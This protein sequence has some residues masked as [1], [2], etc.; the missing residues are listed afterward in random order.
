MRPTNPY[1]PPD[2][3]AVA[4]FSPRFD[5]GKLAAKYLQLL[6]CLSVAAT[7]VGL[8]FF[9]RLNLDISPLLLFW[10]SKHLAN[11]GK[12]A[13]K[14]VIGICYFN[15]IGIAFLFVLTLYYG[16][17]KDSPIEFR[18]GIDAPGILQIALLSCILS[19]LLVIPVWIL[20]TPE[21]KREFAVE[22]G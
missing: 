22:A 18:S 15:L 14:W 11:H 9:D 19:V 3:T 21:A 4:S 10:A 17:G 8:L 20:R 7:L 1:Q 5:A 13:R 2:A 16:T 12:T 6:A